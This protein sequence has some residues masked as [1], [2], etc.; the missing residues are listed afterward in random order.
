[1][2]TPPARNAGASPPGRIRRGTDAR[3]PE[4]LLTV[5]LAAPVALDAVLARIRLPLREAMALE[6]GQRLMI[7]KDSLGRVRL[8]G[9]GGHV[10][11][12]G[13]LGRCD[14]WRALRLSATGA[15]GRGGDQHDRDAAP[16]VA[17]P[18]GTTGTGAAVQDTGAQPDETQTPRAAAAPPERPATETTGP[19]DQAPDTSEDAGDSQ[20]GTALAPV[21]G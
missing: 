11:A 9:V 10:A 14:G 19:K 4:D 18:S 1:M 6:V 2:P 21:S 13:R 16:R 8:A 12:E 17:P 15:Q 20:T 5:A 7:A 3:G